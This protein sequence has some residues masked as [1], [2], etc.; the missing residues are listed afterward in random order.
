VHDG[1]GLANDTYANLKWVQELDNCDALLV[2]SRHL[3]TMR[4]SSSMKFS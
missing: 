4:W 3:P 2:H 1:L